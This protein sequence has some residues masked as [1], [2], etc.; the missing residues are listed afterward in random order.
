[1]KSK[2]TLDY[3]EKTQHTTLPKSFHCNHCNYKTTT[4]GSLK[5]HIDFQHGDTKKIVKWKCSEMGCTYQTKRKC[6]LSEHLRHKHQ[7]GEKIKQFHCKLCSYKTFHH[8]SMKRHIKTHDDKKTSHHHSRL[9]I[10]K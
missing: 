6:H 8:G 10:E 4:K 7:I 9:E 5:T 3:H 2:R 1:M